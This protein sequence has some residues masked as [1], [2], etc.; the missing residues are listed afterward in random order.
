VLGSSSCPWEGPQVGPASFPVSAF[1]EDRINLG[2]K[3]CRWVRVPITPL[4]FLQSYRRWPFQVL[5]PQYSKSQLKSILIFNFISMFAVIH[6][7]GDFWVFSLMSFVREFVVSLL[8]CLKIKQCFLTLLMLQ[9]SL[10]IVVVRTYWQ[11]YL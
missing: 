6:I 5:Y 3:F 11:K 1:H 7:L 8:V 9:L 10:H 2:R 4:R